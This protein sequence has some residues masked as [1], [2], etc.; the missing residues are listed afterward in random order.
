MTGLVI[1][2]KVQEL[3]DEIANDPNI[4]E[5]VV[6]GVSKVTIAIAKMIREVLTIRFKTQVW[7]ILGDRPN[8]V[9]RDLT[10]NRVRFRIS[11]TNEASDSDPNGV[12]FSDLAVCHLSAP[13]EV[14]A[15]SVFTS[16]FPNSTILNITQVV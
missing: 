5:V 8:A 9:V 4:T 11:F 14:T 16:R 3:L 1:K 7:T 12:E 2:N 15:R 13:D 10:A 6:P